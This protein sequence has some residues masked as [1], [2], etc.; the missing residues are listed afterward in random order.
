MRISPTPSTA[1]TLRRL[2]S[3]RSPR[4][5]FLT[6]RAV[7]LS[8]SLSL[9][10]LLLIRPAEILNRIYAFVLEDSLTC[11][12]GNQA[13]QQGCPAHYPYNSHY[14]FSK[15]RGALS[16]TQVCRQLRREFMPLNMKDRR[17][18]VRVHQL[19]DFLA[20]YAPDPLDHNLEG[21]LFVTLQKDPMNWG[22]GDDLW[23]DEVDLTH[24]S[25]LANKGY[26]QTEE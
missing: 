11:P 9:V 21:C 22:N 4:R 6:Y 23:G 12:A 2:V 19:P 17:C 5:V 15:E 24:L 16:L 13:H 10:G 18:I 1:K 26:S 20:R 25:R 8:S 14:T 7:C 3:H